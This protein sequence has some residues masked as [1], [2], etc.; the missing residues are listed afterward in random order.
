MGT[1]VCVGA[2]VGAHGVR[3]QVRVKSFTDDPL[4]VAAYGPVEDEDRTRRFKLKVMG[5]AKGLVIAKLD[6]VDD[7]DAAEALRGT[8]LYVSRDKLP[9]TDEDEFLYSDLVGLRAETADGSVVGTVRGVADFGAG[10]VLDLGTFMVPFTKADV[11]VVDIAGGRVV[12]VSPQYAP[13]DK[14]EA[15]ASEARDWAV[16]APR[17]GRSESEGQAERKPTERS[18]GR[19]SR[20]EKEDRRGNRGE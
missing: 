15:G 2:I 17:S 16:E 19:R 13:D 11:P 1:R 5:E 3:G 4:D 8:R 18:E 7:R 9:E 10:E 20:Q 6:G 12:V 14:D